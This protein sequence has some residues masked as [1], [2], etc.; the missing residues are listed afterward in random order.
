M[1]AI[2]LFTCPKS[3]ADEHIALIQ[4][5]AI[6]SWLQL[7]SSVEVLLVGDD[8]GV[9]DIA[10]EFGIRNPREVAR[11]RESTPLISSI[12]ELA[13]GESI[14]PTLCYVNADI[15][16][17]PDFLTAVEALGSQL[18]NFLMVGQRWDL[19]VGEPLEFSAGWDAKLRVWLK[20]EGRLHPPAGS[21]YFVFPR[22]LRLNMPDFALGRAGWDNWMIFSARAG[23]VPVVDASATVTVV[24]QDHRYDHLPGGLPHYS[25]PE[26]HRNLDLAGGREAMFTLRDSTLR[27]GKLGL[28]PIR[29]REV[30]LSRWL[31]AAAIARLGPGPLARSF[32]MLMHPVDSLTYMGGRI[33]RLLG[34]IEPILS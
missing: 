10:E 34:S 4:R 29:P 12:F 1:P 2:A 31:E 22:A 32:R 14:S 8:T 5:N 3:F 28:S 33:R 24:H 18:D 30:G 25:L 17:L 6:R 26:S 9:A 23:G 15:I 21:D 27:L 7:G 19:A 20:Q 11:N 13:R 16:L